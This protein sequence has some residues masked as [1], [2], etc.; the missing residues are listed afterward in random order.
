MAIRIACSHCDE[1][2]RVSEGK[3]GK[4]LRCSSCGE[5]FVAGE[6]RSKSRRRSWNL[7]NAVSPGLLFAGVAVITGI[8]LFLMRDRIYRMFASKESAPIVQATPKITEPAPPAKVEPRFEPPSGWSAGDA[9][10]ASIPHAERTSTL[11]LVLLPREKPPVHLAATLLESPATGDASAFR[12]LGPIRL[13]QVAADGVRETSTE[14]DARVAAWSPTYRVDEF[15]NLKDR[16]DPAFPEATKPEVKRAALSGMG[17]FELVAL[18]MPNRSVKP[19]E[20]WTATTQSQGIHPLLGHRLRCEWTCTH[21]GNRD[22][23]GR[24]E[25]LVKLEGTLHGASGAGAIGSARGEAVFRSGFG[26]S[27]VSIAFGVSDVESGSEIAWELNVDRVPGNPLRIGTAS[28]SSPVRGIVVLQIQG[29]VTPLDPVLVE[30]RDVRQKLFP[31]KVRSDRM[32]EVYVENVPT[33]ST[34]SFVPIINI[35]DPA[36]RVFRSSDAPG[37]ASQGSRTSLQFRAMTPGLYAVS[38]GSRAQVPGA[39]V[40]LVGERELPTASD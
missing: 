28:P 21:Q 7:P 4:K 5:T 17:T 29:V 10:I 12:L 1:T 2:F 6:T 27:R 18:P 35:L 34:G 13:K 31:L 32:Y 37:V 9:R 16:S 30:Q 11:T 36:G 25:S 8:M 22:A 23:A 20:K 24:T 15:G 38:V 14:S 39:F 33:A 40:L 26:W 19:G 3:L